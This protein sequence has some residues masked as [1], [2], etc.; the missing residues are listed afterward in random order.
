MAGVVWIEAS[1][2]LL[3]VGGTGVSSCAWAEMTS[4]KCRSSAI[5]IETGRLRISPLR[6]R[7]RNQHFGVLIIDAAGEAAIDCLLYTS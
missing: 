7:D 3:C 5:S 4:P 6:L 2:R 1:D